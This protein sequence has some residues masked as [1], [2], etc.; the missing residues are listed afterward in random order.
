MS[1]TD[2]PLAGR[3]DKVRG[4]LVIASNREPYAHR[5]TARG[6]K[7]EVTTG[8]L[9]SALDMVLRVTGGTWVAWGS[10]SG[11]REGAD[12]GSRVWVPPA[13]PAYRLRRVWL[14]RAAVQHYYHGYCNLV[15]WPLF[16]GEPDRILCRTSFWNAYERANRAFAEA[17]LA[18]GSASATIWIHDYHLCL[19]PA[20]VRAASPERTIAHFW[21]VPWPG[22]ELFRAAPQAEA[23]LAGLLG[24][25]LIGFQLALY[26][27]NFLECAAACLGAAIDHE[28]M[29]VSWQGRVTQVRSFPISTDYQRF[30]ALAAT[31]A[32]AAR[33]G[34]FR[35]RHRLPGLVGLAV[36]R[37][38]Y[39]KGIIQRLQA[40]E[41]FFQRHRSF[42]GVFTFVQVAVMT[43][44]GA[45]YRAYR[46]EVEALVARINGRYG[47]AD[48]Q[49]IVYSTTRLD[50]EDLAAAYRLAD[51]AVITPLCDGMNLVAKEYVAA[52]AD[53][54][55][56]LVLGRQA[57]AAAELAGALLVDPMDGDAFVATLRQALTMSRAE[58]R[59]RMARLRH[60]VRQHTIY[61]WVGDILDELALLPQMKGGGKYALRHGAEI[62]ARLAGRG[63]LLCLDFDGTLAPIVECPE[64]AAM[65]ADVRAQLVALRERHPIAVLSG[66]SLADVRAR[67]GLPGLIYGGNHGAEMVGDET[68]ASALAGDRQLLAEFLGEAARALARIPGVLIEDKGVTASIHFRRVAPAQREAFLTAFQPLARQYAGRL[69]ITEGRKVIEIRP[70]A[71]GDKGAAVQR[72]MAGVG[73]G[74]VPVYLGDDAADE[75]AF[76]AVRERGIAVSVGGSPTADYYLR[77]QGEV[78]GFLAL[79]AGIAPGRN[80]QGGGNGAKEAGS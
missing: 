34:R 56:V 20:M 64:R 8:G 68:S 39:T 57:G 49:P 62:A 45:P 43:R 35:S 50:Q 63:L 10:G 58:Q 38:D 22:W 40:L 13:S 30:A 48:W 17:I 78:A 73:S 66:R 36:D 3:G 67:A 28:T 75:D 14:S 51:V 72:L 41:L 27:R 4:G 24:N 16:H 52:R 54:E 15:L 7:L 69:R 80:I 19:V 31:A 26:A 32:T 47:S 6:L 71:A 46:R 37:L 76:R 70:H 1:T 79:L 33:V 60:Q 65:P 59:E 77:N 23:L 12:A 61:G 11:D 2:A 74:M 18:E 21:H 44:N 29:T 9:V 55:G 42:R 53:G 25:D 5:K